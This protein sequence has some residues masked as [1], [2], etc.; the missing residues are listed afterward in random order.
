MKKIMFIIVGLCFCFSSPA[1]SQ[2][3]VET[4][5]FANHKELG[6]DAVIKRSIKKV[7]GVKA[8]TSFEI[9]ASRPG[10]Y[11]ISFWLFPTKL[12]DGSFVCY[13][14]SVNGKV[15]SSKISPTYGDWQSISL[16]NG[17]MIEL[18]KGINYVSV[19]GVVPDVPNVEHIK[20]SSTR[21]E[22]L[23][24]SR[25]Y[26]T[27]KTNLLQQRVVNSEDNVARF[28]S[29]T[30]STISN[31]VTRNSSLRDEPYY[32]YDYSLNVSFNYTFYKTVYFTEGQQVFLATNGVDNFSHIL[33]LFSSDMPENYSW[34]AMSNS[35]CLA[36]LNVTIPHNGMYY[37]RVRSY[38]NARSG[39]CNLNINGQNYYE[40]IPIY[41][42]GV[43]CTQDTNAIYNTFT[44]YNTGD[45]RLWIEEGGSIPGIISAFNDDYATNG[46]FSWGLNPRIKKRYPRPVHAAL[47]SSYSSYNPTGKCDLYI[48]CQ[49]S[50]IMSYFPNL[51]SDDAIQ[52]APYNDNYNCISW[53]GGITSYWEWPLYYGSSFY[54]PNPLTAFDNYYAS[55]GLTR[56]GANETNS[57][58]DLWAIVYTNGQ[59]EYTHGSVRRGADENAHGYD[60][61]SK[62]GS[63]MRT[64]HPRYSL[65]GDDYG[66]VVEHYIRNTNRVSLLEEE[67]ADGTSRIEYVDFDTNEREILSKKINAIH[68]GVLLKFQKMYDK[69]KNVTEN[70][71]YS[72]PKQI[73]NCE[74]YKEL[75][76]YCKNNRELL[77]AI[78]ERLSNGDGVAATELIG[79]LTFDKHLS[80]MHEIRE[81]AKK[82]NLDGIKTIRP[83]QSNFMAYVKKL[84]SMEGSEKRKLMRGADETTGITYSNFADYNITPLT[85]GISVE[86]ELS[87]S[88]NVTLNLIDLAGNIVC[89]AVNGKVLESG[90]HSFFMTADKNRSY[91]VQ[92][93]LDGRINVKKIT[94]K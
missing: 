66:V 10:K 81:G 22:S 13:D 35:N 83:I 75:L 28:S 94:I 63:L 73:A 4:D 72:N 59:R 58:V 57:V 55:R 85:N 37:V 87:K 5:Y 14:V 15:L 65:E 34:A 89:S 52:S 50:D 79:D 90:R 88:T 24:D 40:N 64:F 61:E 78:Y 93:M 36:S 53:S 56:N 44:C 62:P 82:A 2:Q 31:M 30:L 51:Q 3:I 18:N 69:W 39:L 21:N 84:L 16:S 27:Y 45:P 32:N 47:L 29:D 9:E 38:L 17:E 49:N 76:E 71:I 41:S 86:F 67:I 74:E 8:I 33:E 92:L 46:D 48:K 54:S 68:Q 6:G 70:T 11:Y 20:V 80:V 42:I 7:E 1:F 60:W 25:A 12:N 91:L 77:Y 23:I 19:I 43:R 26:D